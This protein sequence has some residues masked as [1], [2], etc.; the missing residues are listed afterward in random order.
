MRQR[1]PLF[2]QP[3]REAGLNAFGFS[4]LLRLVLR[5]QPRSGKQMQPTLGL[6]KTLECKPKV[7]P[8]AQPWAE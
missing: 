1:F 8:A 7:A 2:E 5:T 4:S 3:Q 6:W